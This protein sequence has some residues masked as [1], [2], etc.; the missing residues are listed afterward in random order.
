M[1]DALENLFPEDGGHGGNVWAAARSLGLRPGDILDLSTNI[2]AAMAGA[3]ASLLGSGVDLE[4]LRYPDPQSLRLRAAMAEAEGVPLDA[5]L[6]GNGASE[7]I[8]AVLTGLRPRKALFLGPLFTEYAKACDALGIAWEVAMPPERGDSSVAVGGFAPNRDTLARVAASDADMVIACSP[9]NPGT[10][11]LLEPEALVEAAGGR[12]LVLDASYKDFLGKDFMGKDFLGKGF[13][14]GF[15]DPDISIWEKHRYTFLDAVAQ[16]FGA[17]LVLLGSL[18]KF[19]ACPGIRLGFLISRPD[20]AAR[21]ARA[22]PAW[23]ISTAAEQAGMRLLGQREKYF[24]ALPGLRHDVAVLAEKLRAAGFF[25]RVFSGVSFALAGLHEPK[26]AR[27]LRDG[28][29]TGRHVLVRVCDNIPGMPG[30]YVRIQARPEADMARL[31]AGLDDFG[32]T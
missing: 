26:Q 16:A 15:A 25:A 14:G 32:R 24:S 27:E 1:T 17:R 21:I 29:L 7:L 8:W 4:P 11:L 18:T 6:P 5:I 12:T 19:Y 22:R 30:G 28:L 10:G 3:T 9:N 31:W 23:T 13:S 2:F 20:T